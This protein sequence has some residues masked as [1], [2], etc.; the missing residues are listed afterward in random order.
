MLGLRML[1]LVALCLLTT[2][3][4][5][6]AESLE[7]LLRQAVAAQQSGDTATAIRLYKEVLEQRPDLGQV[8]SNLGAALAGEGR[9]PE[10]IEQ[11]ELALKGLPGNPSITLNLALAYYKLGRYQEAAGWLARLQPA[12]PEN[13]QVADLLA[14]CW[15]Q[16]GKS[17]QVIDLLT[18]LEQTHPEDH[19]LAFLL[20]TALLDQDRPDLAEVVLNRILGDGGSAEAQLLLG[21]SKMKAH[22]FAGATPYLERAVKLNPKLPFVHAYYGRALMAT[23][24]TP[25]ATRE[26]RAELQQNP[27]DFFSNL[28]LALLLKQ[29]DKLDEALPRV[30]AALRVR[31]DDPGAL[32]QLA[33]IDILLGRNQQA[34]AELERLTKESP[35]FTEAQVSL[36]TVYYRLKRK[37]DGNRV[38]AIVRKLQEEDQ[39]RQPGANEAGTGTVPVERP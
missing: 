12:Q 29:E 28:N 23:G 13:V 33:S 9:F 15:I 7:S 21:A 19:A 27:F 35:N 30:D 38:R 17:A 10:A 2:V 34:L 26:F 20:G 11:Y 14:S 6:S 8:R 39:K 22:D 24:D 32:Y 36:A 3:G 31:P 16:L 4:H 18:P 37:E 1:A 25:A 5:A